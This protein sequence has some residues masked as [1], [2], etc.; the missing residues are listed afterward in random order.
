MADRPALAGFPR[1]RPDGASPRWC[2]SRI[3]GHP[4]PAAGPVG[5]ASTLTLFLA[6]YLLVLAFFIVLVSIS[7]TEEVKSNAVMNSLT[8]VFASAQAPTT[9]PT[10][11]VADEGDVIAAREHQRAI[12]DAF[13]T[14]LRI[15]RVEKLQPGRL[16]RVTVPARALFEDGR[17]TLRPSSRLLFDRIAAALGSRPAG[18]RFELEFTV[19]RSPEGG[20]RA[21]EGAS[22]EIDRAGGFAREM[23]GRGA[24]PDA[25]SVAVAP[26]D[27]ERV[28]MTFHVR[29]RGEGDWVGDAVVGD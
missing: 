27:P 9:S 13:A 29:S 18:L 10:A 25:L 20:R 15:A 3:V 2:R 24:P 22:L 19:G 23:L 7:T 4:R 28:S 12:S 14:H 5:G 26:G 17:P 11:F 8:S 1:A 21:I 16:M 6:L